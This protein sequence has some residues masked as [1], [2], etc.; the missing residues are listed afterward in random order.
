MAGALSTDNVSAQKFGIDGFCTSTTDP[1]TCLN[2]WPWLWSGTSTYFTNTGNVGIGTAAPAAKLDVAGEIRACNGGQCSHLRYAGSDNYLRGN[3]FFN[4]YLYDEANTGYYV[5]PSAGSNFNFLCM[6]GWC[7]NRFFPNFPTAYSEIYL[8]FAGQSIQCNQ[9]GFGRY[10]Y[11]QV[12]S[13]GTVQVKAATPEVGSDT[14][15][16][17]AAPVN[18]SLIS[19]GAAGSG[20]FPTVNSRMSAYACASYACGT[21]YVDLNGMQGNVCSA[22]W[23]R[24]W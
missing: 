20:T 24:V 17:T 18:P 7:R 5:K 13:D 4:G 22:N 23:T 19:Y 14:G 11:A 10:N 15:W 12:L 6:N 8:P 21:I 1:T 16:I 9:A 3:T 2:R